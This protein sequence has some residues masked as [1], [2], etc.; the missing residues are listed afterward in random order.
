M[1]DQSLID[2]L[3]FG[4]TVW[5]EWKAKQPRIPLLDLSEADFSEMSV[6]L[7]GVDLSFCNLRGCTLNS[8]QA[9]QGI[10]Y[11]ADLQGANLS[12]AKLNEANFYEADLSFAI[13]AGAILIGANF[14]V[15]S[16]RATN[17]SGASLVGAQ[18]GVTTL[19]GASLAG[20]DLSG[21]N[22]SQASLKG[23]DFSACAF[24]LTVFGDL[25]L[26]AAKGL[27]RIKDDGRVI[28]DIR[29]IYESNGNIPKPFLRA[30]GFPEAFLALIPTLDFEERDDEAQGNKIEPTEEDRRMPS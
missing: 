19:D 15:A 29:S 27:D 23:T 5:N 11:Y 4:V 18:F 22:F 13:L 2:R 20:A 25:D 8:L 21:A 17:L 16:L 10:F 24:D 9:E 3:K 7:K 14:G 30:A 26:S 6:P 12:R 28:L 1:A